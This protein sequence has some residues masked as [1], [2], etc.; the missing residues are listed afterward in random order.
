MVECEFLQQNLL[1]KKFKF[2]DQFFR[3]ILNNFYI[4]KN[5]FLESA[6]KLIGIFVLRRQRLRRKCNLPRK[7]FPRLVFHVGT[8]LPMLER[9]RQLRDVARRRS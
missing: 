3:K 5:I 4:E 8:V 9:L 7:F 2:F 1:L 6:W